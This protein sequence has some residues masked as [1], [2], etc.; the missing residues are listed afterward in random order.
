MAAMRDILD[1]LEVLVAC[2]TRNPPRAMQ[3]GDPV[4]E[5]L[6]NE[7]KGFDVSVND[8][9]DGSI[10][11]LGVRGRPKTVFNFHLDTVPVTDG[12]THNPFSLSVDNERA[13]GLGAC[14]IKGAL[15][16]MLAAAN[17]SSGD[18]AILITTDEE[19]GVGVAVN[20]FLGTDHGFNNAIVAEP[21]RCKAV[22][23]HRGITTA[24]VVFK[25][26]AGHASSD[27]VLADSANHCAIRW[28]NRCLAKAESWGELE[29]NGLKG[30]PFNIGRIDG[31]IKPNMI[32][33]RCEMRIGLRT[34]P[35]QNGR[36]L[37]QGLLAEIP[38]DE[39]HESEITFNA[40]SLPA[41]S[42]ETGQAPSAWVQQLGLN[43]GPAVNFWSEAALFSAAG[44]HAMV[45]GSGDIAQ[46]HTADEWVE[47][48]QLEELAKTYSRLIENAG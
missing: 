30:V 22:T 2:D 4:F 45:L 36:E 41:T 17:A 34:L 43:A 1:R 26:I 14:D 23:A 21:T 6:R 15:A 11:L 42:G 44:L 48:S 46:A 20:A 16:S 31:G 19:A 28:A 35:G 5:F 38:P 13:V 29:Q 8:H 12:W 37:V 24:R 3:S 40:P 10:G 33:E 47:L 7:L 39:L 25:G 32:A 27:R 9:G 18:L